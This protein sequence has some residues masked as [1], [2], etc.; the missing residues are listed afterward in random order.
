[1]KKQLLLLTILVFSASILFAQNRIPRHSKMYLQNHISKKYKVNEDKKTDYLLKVI[2]ADSKTQKPFIIK[3][4]KSSTWVRDSIYYYDWDSES[5]NMVFC[6][7]CLYSYDSNGNIISEVYYEWDSELNNMVLSSKLLY[8]YDTNG[9]NIEWSFYGWDTE[10]NDWVGYWKEVYTYDAN[11]NLLEYIYYDWDSGDSDWVGCYKEV[12]TYD[13]NG[14]LLEKLCYSWDSEFSSWVADDKEVYTYDANGNNVEYIKYYWDSGLEDWVVS[15]KEEYSFNNNDNLT[16]TVYYSWDTGLNDWKAGLRDTCSY[17]VYGNLTEILTYQRAP[18]EKAE[19]NWVVSSKKEYSYDINGNITEW[20]SYTWS[21]ETWLGM[22]KNIYTYDSNGNTTEEVEYDWDSGHNSW[23]GIQKY[24]YTYDSNGSM[25]EEAYYEWNSGTT[26][27]VESCKEVYFWSLFTSSTTQTVTDY[28]GNIYN[29]VQIGDQIWMAENLKTTHYAD[30]T[31]LVDGFEAGDI[32]GDYTTKYYFAYDDNVG[33]VNTYGRLYTWAAVMDGSAGSTLNPSG[34]QGVCPDGWH[35]PSNTEVEELVSFIGSEGHN[36]SEGTALKSASGWKNS[37][38]GTDNYGFTALPGG[39]FDHDGTFSGDSSL[40]DWWTSSVY[41][42]NESIEWDMYYEVSVV[43]M[44]NTEKDFGFSVRCLKDEQ[45]NHPPSDILLKN[46][47]FNENNSIS[48]AVDTIDVIDKDGDNNHTITFVEQ[49]G[50]DNSNFILEGNVLKTNIVFNFE[51]KNSYSLLLQAEDNSNQTFQKEVLLMV[52]DI[53]ET[54]EV[55]N[56]LVDQITREDELYSYTIPDTIFT[57]PDVGDVL[58]YSATLTDGTDLPVWLTITGTTGI[59]SGTP[60]DMDVKSIRVTAE[61]SEGLT[62]T[63]DFILVVEGFEEITEEEITIDST[64]TNGVVTVTISESLFTNMGLGTDINYTASL[65]DG[66]ALPSNIVFDQ[67]TLTFTITVSSNKSFK[68]IMSALDLIVTG[69]DSDGYMA[70]IGLTVEGTFLSDGVDIFVNL[71]I[72]PN[73]VTDKLIIE[74]YY[75][76]ELQIEMYDLIG[77]LVKKSIITN[78]NGE[79]D[80][81]ALESSM[82]L[83]KITIQD[84]TKIVKIIK[85]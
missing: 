9:N 29:T 72:Y 35:V 53:N 34:V 51:E 26:D 75:G 78:D 85:N 37:G 81:Q 41:D 13:V 2:D 40:G 4:V 59:L 69:V 12:Y 23:L 21:S 28:D 6:E 57:D 58:T 48:I 7:K 43:D 42:A 15:S 52:N 3:D 16:E 64:S 68:E 82:Y 65:S 84:E 47:N 25:T 55:K 76:K 49:E 19:I 30:G 83:L 18:G 63:D 61:D 80:V 56:N 67:V 60:T 79:I 39:V 38:N 10:L 27:W 8:S 14:N 77:K 62:A 24:I 54:P 45:I 36:G 1:M 44:G 5:S 20:I 11:R 22:E 50:Y 46:G 66:S 33:N 71:K 31:A 32:R 70:T 74:N 17:D 73:P